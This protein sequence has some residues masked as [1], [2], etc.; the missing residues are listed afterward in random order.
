L[1]GIDPLAVM[2]AGSRVYDGT[3]LGAAGILGATN[4]VSGDVLTLAGTVELAG[5]NVGTQ[6]ITGFGALTLGGASAGNYTLAGA[7]GAVTITPAALT[8]AA[9]DAAKIVGH[10]LSFAGTEFTASGLVGGDVVAGLSLT[11]AGAGAAATMAG[12]PY[13]IVPSQAVGSGLGNYVIAYVNGALTVN[14]PPNTTIVE[15][16][17][18]AGF[19]RGAIAYETS[20]PVSAP[21]LTA[22]TGNPT[23]P[24]GITISGALL[25][26]QAALNAVVPLS[27]GDADTSDPDADTD[28]ADGSDDVTGTDAT[29]ALFL[30]P[31]LLNLPPTLL[32]ISAPSP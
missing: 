28:G 22:P 12:S 10:T 23:V 4:L 19:D 27:G 9:D 30:D 18:S 3:A 15:S 5:R 2:V 6:A 32:R 11:S 24:E 26:N 29:G 25:A 1:G 20:A 7:S 13:A 8:I 16:M 21:G 14:P 31:V 17:L